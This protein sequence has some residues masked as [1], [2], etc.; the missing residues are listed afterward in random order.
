MPDVKAAVKVLQGFSPLPTRNI[1]VFASKSAAWLCH[2]WKHQMKGSKSTWKNWFFLWTNLVSWKIAV[3]E[4]CTDW[5]I[6]FSPKWN[7]TVLHLLWAATLSSSKGGPFLHSLTFTP[8]FPN[9]LFPTIVIFLLHLFLLPSSCRSTL[10]INICIC[11]WKS[12][13]SK[14][15][16]AEV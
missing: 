5:Q 3:M 4:F 1:S 15:L 9:N 7:C 6:V 11:G 13:F 14:L 8:F 12:A 2:L 10:I 16:L